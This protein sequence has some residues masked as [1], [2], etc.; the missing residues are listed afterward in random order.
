MPN[1]SSTRDEKLHARLRRPVNNAYAMSTVVNYEPLMDTTTDVFFRELTS[2]FVRP[3]MECDLA[4]WLQMYAF[5]VLGDITFSKRFGFLEAG[6]DLEDMLH[7]TAKHMEY[8]GTM[9]QLPL[10]DKLFRLNNPVARFLAK[11]N[12]IVTFTIKNIHGDAKPLDEKAKPDFVTRFQMAREKYPDIMTD[13]QLIDYAVTNVSAGSDTTAIIFRAA[14]FY[15]LTDPVSLRKVMS[16]IKQILALRA[17]GVHSTGHLSWTE[18]QQMPF[19]QACIK[20]SLRL[21][22]ALGMVLPRVVPAEGTTLCGV[23]IPGGTEVGCNAWTVHRDQD[24]Y[25][26]D[27]DLWAPER[28][29]DSNEET[30]KVLERYNFA[31]GAGSRTC[32]W[33][34]V[35]ITLH[36]TH[37]DTSL[38]RHWTSRRYVGNI[39]AHT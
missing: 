10:L 37:A 20:E 3:G 8:L 16:E 7:H 2:R 30:V 15:L 38:C 24:V 5:D 4:T 25:G 19:L 28:W 14:L 9:G 33:F 34:I 13:S 23:F 26:D 35:L 1:L 31:F 21:H 29:L 32:K 6:Y 17:D 22:P 12:A 36:A 11:T 18:A 27:A 39:E